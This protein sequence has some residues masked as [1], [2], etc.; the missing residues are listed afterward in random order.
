MVYALVLETSGETRAGSSPVPGTKFVLNKGI[1]IMP[2]VV[3][4]GAQ[5]GDEGKGKI[6][7][8]YAD[9]AD[10][11]VRFNG[12]ANAGHTLVVDGEKVITH[13]IPSGVLRP[14]I[15]CVLG[16]GMVIDPIEL[17]EEIEWLKIL[18]YLSDNSKLRIAMGAHVVT[19]WHKMLDGAKED[20]GKGNG[21][22]RKGIGPAY[23]SK[24]ARRGIRMIDLLNPKR[25]RDLIHENF[26][27]YTTINHDEQA[28]FLAECGKLLSG[29][30]VDASDL[31]NDALDQNKN[32][33]IEGAQAALLDIDHGQ[34]PFVSSSHATAGG[35]CASLGLGPK[36]IDNVIGV[37]K[38]YTTAVGKMPFAT[39]MRP[40]IAD[41]W[42]EAGDEYGSTTGR[43]RRI[44]WLDIPALKRAARINGMDYLAW[45]KLDILEAR[46]EDNPVVVT[47]WEGNYPVFEEIPK[48]PPEEII[49][50]LTNLVGVKSCLYSTGPGREQTTV[51]FH[52]FK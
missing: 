11:V 52:P 43:P 27:S 5:L 29:Y 35:A 4:V 9:K 24:A 1:R 40:D 31:V 12:G 20:A 18:G 2:A 30:F 33:I 48:G 45:V 34:Y 25:L 15:T 36:R 13:L 21:S 47:G 16:E 10:M 49:E 19:P 38:V 8:L 50:Y 42:R 46:R 23:E 32:V 39:E 7:D 41:R 26:G 3:I 28:E 44:G 14:H 22:T 6:T 37:A 17:V 51:N